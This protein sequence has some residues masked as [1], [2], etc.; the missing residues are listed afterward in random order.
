MTF[1]GLTVGGDRKALL[2]LLLEEEKRTHY[3]WRLQ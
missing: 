2:V 1:G 3:G